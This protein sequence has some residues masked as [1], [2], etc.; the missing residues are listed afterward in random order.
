MYLHTYI[1]IS[2]TGLKFQ[3]ARSPQRLVSP[4][5]EC[6]QRGGVRFGS[7]YA[8]TRGAGVRTILRYLPRLFA[9]QHNHQRDGPSSQQPAA[10]GNSHIAQIPD[11]VPCTCAFCCG[12]HYRSIEKESGAKRRNTHPVDT[13]YLLA[14]TYPRGVGSFGTHLSISSVKVILNFPH[15]SSVDEKIDLIN[16]TV[17]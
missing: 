16:T 5:P 1:C 15:F 12:R 7:T 14:S 8:S 4:Y 9:T 10:S 13:R 6:V 11:T 17:Y 3:G 2:K